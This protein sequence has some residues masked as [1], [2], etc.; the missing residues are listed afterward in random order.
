MARAPASTKAARRERRASEEAVVGRRVDPRDLR[1]L[2]DV[3]APGRPIEVGHGVGPERGQHPLAQAVGGELGVVLQLRGRRVGGGDDLDVEAVEQG[4]RA[5]ARVGDAGR[6]PCHRWRRPFRRS[7]PDRPRT[8]RPARVPASSGTA[9]RGRAS[10]SR[11]TYARSCASRSRPGRRR[12]AARR[13][14]PAR[15][16][17]RP[18]SGTRSGR[19]RSAAA[20]GRRTGCRRRRPPA[21]H[22]RACR[23]AAGPSSRRR[24]PGRRCAARPGRGARG[25]DGVQATTSDSSIGY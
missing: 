22:A 9:C 6:D 1:Q 3:V 21:P 24:S 15:C 19:E 4:A 16:L 10:S 11:R 23:S 13:A 2:R 12:A 8:P 7:G 5:E 17:G 14:G 18:A 20:P 25:Q